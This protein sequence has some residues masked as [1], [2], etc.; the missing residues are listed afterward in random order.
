ML[1]LWTSTKTTR[2]WGQSSVLYCSIFYILN[3]RKVF[4]WEQAFCLLAWVVH[5]QQWLR[6]TEQEHAKTKGCRWKKWPVNILHDLYWFIYQ[7][8]AV[9]WSIK[10]LPRVQWFDSLKEVLIF[11]LGTICSLTFMAGRKDRS[12]SEEDLFVLVHIKYSIFQEFE[13]WHWRNLT[14]TVLLPLSTPRAWHQADMQFL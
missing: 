12:S 4:V 9:T 7:R 8:F 10:T 2:Q 1:T 14:F 6:Y 11:N 5:S 3:E 13:S